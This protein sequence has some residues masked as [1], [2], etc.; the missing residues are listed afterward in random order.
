M[1]PAEALARLRLARTDGIWPVTFRRLLGHHG[2]AA[3]ALAALPRLAA[4]RGTPLTLCPE[5][6][7]LREIE[8]LRRLGGQFVFAGEPPYPPLLDMQEDAPPVLAILGDPATLAG[9]AVALV[10]ARNASAAG[11]RIAEDLAEQLA[12]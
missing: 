1:I 7:A 3:N 10:G 6:D 8:A 9:R 11:R 4:R 5:G 2:S 12:A